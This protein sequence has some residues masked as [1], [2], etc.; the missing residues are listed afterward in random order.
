LLFFSSSFFGSLTGVSFYGVLSFLT[1][2]TGG[3]LTALVSFSTG[4]F[5]GCSFVVSELGAF[6]VEVSFNFSEGAGYF[7]S[8]FS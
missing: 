7:P 8:E 2:S 1:S 6:L 3:F 4:C 5:F